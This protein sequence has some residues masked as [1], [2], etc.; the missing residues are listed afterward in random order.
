MKLLNEAKDLL[1]HN[2][3]ESREIEIDSPIVAV[4]HVQNHDAHRLRR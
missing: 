1:F 2:G 4:R 3:E